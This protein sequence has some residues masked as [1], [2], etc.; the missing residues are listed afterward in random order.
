MKRLVTI[1]LQTCN[2]TRSTQKF[3]QRCY[4]VNVVLF[5]IQSRKFWTKVRVL[6]TLSCLLS[7][8]AIVMEK[9]LLTVLRTKPRSISYLVMVPA[10]VDVGLQ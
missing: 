2:L 9:H 3:Y 10:V 7:Y 1:C 6:G 4:I 5:A 8:F